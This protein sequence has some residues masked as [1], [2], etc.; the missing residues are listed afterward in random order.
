MFRKAGTWRCVELV[1]RIGLLTIATTGL[2][3]ALMKQVLMKLIL[4]ASASVAQASTA[5]VGAWKTDCV[6]FGRHSYISLLTFSEDSLVI[7]NRFFETED[8]TSHSI[9]GTYVGKFSVDSQINDDVYQITHRPTSAKFTLHLP[10]VVEFWNNLAGPDGCELKNWILEEAQEVLGRYCRPFKMP[11]VG[12]SV[13]DLI[14]FTGEEMKLGRSP[15]LVGML[16][17][18][19]TLPAPVYRKIH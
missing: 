7:I 12:S 10:H 15:A 2:T 11:E 18:G 6:V 5:P 9:T 13:T 8:C 17:Q 19:S 14:S 16:S 4:M 3:F 1:F